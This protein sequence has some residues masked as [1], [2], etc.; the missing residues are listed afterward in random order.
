MPVGGVASGR[1]CAC[2]LCK[3]HQCDVCDYECEK[4]ITLKKH[5]NTKHIDVNNRNGDKDCQ[6]TTTIKSTHLYCNEC[7]Y[8][9]QKFFFLKK[10]KAHMHVSIM[11]NTNITCNSCGRKFI[12][13]GEHNIHFKEEHPTCK[14]TTD[15]VCDGCIAEWL[16]KA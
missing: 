10:H 4:E 6:V 7:D 5:K 15:S 2:S 1:V 11:E 14:C 16:P 3:K 8:S 13:E 9:C 12:H